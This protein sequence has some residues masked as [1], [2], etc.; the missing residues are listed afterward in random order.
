M[1]AAQYC[2][3]KMAALADSLAG[4]GRPG[5]AAAAAARVAARL[6]PLLPDAAL[7]GPVAAA[8]AAA[9]VAAA[10]AAPLGRRASSERSK[11]TVARWATGCRLFVPLAFSAPHHPGLKHRARTAVLRQEASCSPGA[12]R[13]L[14]GVRYLIV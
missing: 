7:L 9:R 2:G 1:E 14:S 5:A 3:R 4:C 6:A 13:R 8:W 12:S 11:A 10:G